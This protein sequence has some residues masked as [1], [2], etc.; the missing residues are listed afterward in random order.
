MDRDG[1]RLEAG[2]GEGRAGER[3]PGGQLRP[4]PLVIISPRHLPLCPLVMSP[5]HLSSSSSLT[6]WVREPASSPH[7]LLAGCGSGK[8]ERDPLFSRSGLAGAVAA[9]RRRRPGVLPQLGET[10]ER[11]PGSAA[12]RF[13]HHRRARSGVGV[14]P[15]GRRNLGAGCPRAKPRPAWLAASPRRGR[16]RVVAVPCL[17]CCGR[18]LPGERRRG[19]GEVGA[20]PSMGAGAE[21]GAVGA[22]PGLRGYGSSGHEGPARGG[23]RPRRT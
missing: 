21:A 6:V 9:G 11:Q 7:Q 16:E 1:K 19:G 14:S 10:G 2:E 4:S 3:W 8:G 23:T 15:G 20:S 22:M 17:G 13:R 18:R 12:V 5:C